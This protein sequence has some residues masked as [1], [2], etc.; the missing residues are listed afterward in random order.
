MLVIVI[1]DHHFKLWGFFCKKNGKKCETT[2]QKSCGF[3]K[4]SLWRPELGQAALKGCP[5]VGVVS[6]QFF[7]LCVMLFIF[8]MT[9]LKGSSLVFHVS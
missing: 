6:S 1:E 3:S 5:M 2:N 4:A 7:S 9:I 8:G